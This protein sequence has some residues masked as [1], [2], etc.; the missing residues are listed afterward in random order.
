MLGCMLYIMLH[1]MLYM[2][3]LIQFIDH[4]L[5]GSAKAIRLI[6]SKHYKIYIYI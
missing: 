2:N 3:E 4:V 1:I 5:G 6:Y